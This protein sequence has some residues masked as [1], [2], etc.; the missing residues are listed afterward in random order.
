MIPSLRHLSIVAL[1]SI[2]FPHVQAQEPKSSATAGTPH[3]TW[4]RLGEV[5]PDGWIREQM[6]RDLKEGFAGHLDELCKEAN[7]D[8]FVTGRN[9]LN[10]ANTINSVHCQWWNGETEG[11]WWAGF[12]MMAYLSGDKDS[13][14]K[15]DAYVAHILAA[16]DSD[17]YMGV[18]SPDLRYK[19]GGEL[20]TQACLFRG[21]LDDVELTGNKDVLKAVE[22]A[23]H[24][25][26]KSLTGKGTSIKFGVAGHD[27]MFCDVLERLYDLT[28]DVTYRDFG[29]WLYENACKTA[30]G[31][32]SS[33]RSLLDSYAGLVGHGAD[34]YEQIRV[35]LW[36]WSVTGRE[37]LDTAW[38]NGIDKISRHSYPGGAA[39]SQEYIDDCPPDPTFTEFEYCAAKELQWSMESALQ[40][41]GETR[42]ADRT[43]LIWFNDEQ[44]GRLANGSALT[45]LTNENRLRCDDMTPDGLHKQTRNRF[46]PTQKL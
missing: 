29:K 34:T 16:Q 31:D 37:D 22:Q 15:A 25:T 4:L 20:W 8:I 14:A 18:N 30:P 41:T 3:F 12:I 39:V 21:L 13:I 9:G 26:M 45:Y 35:P 43:E 7:S 46:S 42:F 27:L 44:G 40:K 5:K 19:A 33:L 6:A 1:L 2:T 28:G 24:Y 23:V 17:G 36:L 11:N 10:R 38:R 32:D